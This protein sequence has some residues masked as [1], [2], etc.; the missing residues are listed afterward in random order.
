MTAH[1]GRAEIAREITIQI[2][3][4]DG[5]DM[6]AALRQARASRW[7]SPGVAATHRAQPTRRPSRLLEPWL[8][9]GLDLT[10]CRPAP[11]RRDDRRGRPVPISRRLRAASPQEVPGAALDDHRAWADRLTAWRARRRRSAVAFSSLVLA[12]TVL[13]VIFATRGAMSGNRR[14]HRG[15]AF[16]R[17][18]VGLHRTRSSRRHFLLLGLRGGIAGRRLRQSSSSSLLT[19]VRRRATSRRPR[20]TRSSAL[21][22]DFSIGVGLWPG[23]RGDRHRSAR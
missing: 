22:G 10:S 7:A 17:R 4:A 1:A 6:D 14:H 20:A 3:P 8:G 9:T 19:L 23:Y 15:A 11:R 13:T 21:F 5:V 18:R 2:R 16:R 12:A